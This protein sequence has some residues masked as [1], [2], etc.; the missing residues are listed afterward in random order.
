MRKS[1]ISLVNARTRSAVN[2]APS[3]VERKLEHP[4]ISDTLIS[5]Q[6]WVYFSGQLLRSERNFRHDGSTLEKRVI[7]F[8]NA[9]VDRD[10][11]SLATDPAKST[12]VLN[13]SVQAG[14]EKP[15]RA[16][17]T[18]NIG[19][20]PID[21]EVGQP[22][23]WFISCHLPKDIFDQLDEEFLNQNAR[24]LSGACTTD[25]WIS[26]EASSASLAQGIAWFLGPGKH[27]TPEMGHGHLMLFRWSSGLT[28]DGSPYQ[29]EQMATN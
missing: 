15:N 19:Y 14:L 5:T 26:P 2:S 7:L 29:P 20:N 24:F 3:L 18:V 21:K 27:A 23:E 1:H 6:R 9:N 17:W 4:Q 22:D 12:S 25:M 16:P 28:M 8:G 11:V 13:L 10:R